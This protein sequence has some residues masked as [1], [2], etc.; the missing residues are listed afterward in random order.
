MSSRWFLA[1]GAVAAAGAAWWLFGRPSERE[2]E[3]FESAG[4]VRVGPPVDEPPG[5]GEASAG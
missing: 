1:L 5:E 2:E 4:V 3:W